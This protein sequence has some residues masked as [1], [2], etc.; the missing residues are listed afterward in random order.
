MKRINLFPTIL[1]L[2]A[3]PLFTIKAGDDI[4]QIKKFSN[5]TTDVTYQL[6]N[7]VMVGPGS[8]SEPSS[9]FWNSYTIKLVGY[10]TYNL[11]E[12]YTVWKKE[13]G[14]KTN[15]DDRDGITPPTNVDTEQKWKDNILGGDIKITKNGSGDWCSCLWKCN[16][17]TATNARGEST[18]QK[19][20]SAAG[21]RKDF[22][23]YTASGNGRPYIQNLESKCGNCN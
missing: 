20:C 12:G 5:N 22:A 7:G 10:K 1:F 11:S 16:N 21:S 2:I 9:E 23:I 19:I 18:S 15:P 8:S 6:E 3:C 4:S 14:Y 17:I 13:K